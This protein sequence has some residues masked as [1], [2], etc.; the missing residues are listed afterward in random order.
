MNVWWQAWLNL[1]GTNPMKINIACFLCLTQWK[2]AFTKIPKKIPT[3]VKNSQKAIF[4]W[5]KAYTSVKH[6]VQAVLT[7]F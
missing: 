7:D 2:T 4:S 5:F 6:K 3:K 1:K